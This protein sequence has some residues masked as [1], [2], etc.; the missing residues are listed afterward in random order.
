MSIGIYKIEN[1]INNKKYIGQS[2]HIEKRWLEHCQNSSE[3]LIGKALKKYGK[4]NFSF[5]ILEQCEL[6][7]LDELEQYYI[8]K[9]NTIVPLGYNIILP[10]INFKN[11]IFQNYDFEIFK[12]IIE[13]IK[14]N[15]N[16]SFKD[17]ANKY[18]LDLSMIY[19]LNR[20][21]YHTQEN[22]KYPLR[23]VKD[24]SKKLHFCIDCGVEISKGAIR[25]SKC[26][27]QKQQICNRPNRQE[28]KDMIRNY[29]FTHIAKIYGVSDKSISKWC[30]ANNLP[31]LKKEIKQYT[32]EDWKKI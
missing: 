8:Q 6:N 28:L 32:D 1:L 11:Q 21:D 20:G 24:F 18:D 25:C 7:K 12:E 10:S 4:E 27:H 16:L 13:D 2:I 22:E 9:Y 3:S 30:K 23:E 26:S 5:Q 17:I 14:N 31:C 19:Y 15:L 29:S